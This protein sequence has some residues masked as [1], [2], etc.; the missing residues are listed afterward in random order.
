MNKD[1]ENMYIDLIEDNVNVSKTSDGKEFLILLASLLGIIFL[2]IFFADFFANI[3]ISAIPDST[4]L[5]IERLFGKLPKDEMLSKQYE[6][7]FKLLVISREKI[8]SHDNS[9]KGKSTFP[10]IVVKNEDVNAWVEPNGTISFTSAMLDKNLSEEELAFVLAHEIGHYKHR[11]HLK[12]ISRQIII[13][14]ACQII[15]GQNND[16][17]GLVKDVTYMNFLSHSRGQEKNAD[18]Y[19]NEM[20]I[21]IYGNNNGG[22]KFFKRLDEMHN[23]PELL[24]YFSTHP[25]TKQRIKYIKNFSSK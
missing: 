1:L 13:T 15:T 17:S 9:L 24:N 8:I 7:P 14:L 4:Q 11:D 25:S 20:M 6:K 12:T 19:A 5:K 10:I 21:S 2:V 16:L 18:K 3:F 22:I 23:L